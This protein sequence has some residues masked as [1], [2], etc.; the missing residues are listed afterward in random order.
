MA[1]PELLDVGEVAKYLRIHPE[2]VKKWIRQGKLR[3]IKCGNKWRCPL[4]LLLVD[5]WNLRDGRQGG[6]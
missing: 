3:G 5:I 1:L 2:T 4:N 6:N